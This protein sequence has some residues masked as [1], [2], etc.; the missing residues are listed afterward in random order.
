MPRISNMKLRVI[1]HLVVAACVAMPV[2]RARLLYMDEIV[3]TCSKGT[4]PGELYYFLD[5]EGHPA[6]GYPRCFVIDAEARFYIPEVATYTG[7]RLHK[8][9]PNGKF[10]VMWGLLASPGVRG[11]YRWDKEAEVH[12]PLFGTPLAV[13][14]LAVVSEGECYLALTRAGDPRTLVNKYSAE[15]RFLYHLGP[16]GVLTPQELTKESIQRATL[17]ADIVRLAVTASGHLVVAESN[18]DGDMVYTFDSEGKLLEKRDALPPELAE[19]AHAHNAAYD[20]LA[21]AFQAEEK[22]P[23][24]KSHTVLAPDGQLYYMVMVNLKYGAKLEIHRLTF[25]QQ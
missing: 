3:V 8:F 7:I 12:V 6:P 9:K 18:T 4:G 13:H 11:G 19:Q 15:G 21:A 20:K 23:P 14:A 22:E 5:M 2:A 1:L 24:P 17:F 10:K 25:S 16:K